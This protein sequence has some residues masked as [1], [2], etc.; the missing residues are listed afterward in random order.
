MSDNPK[1]TQI[2]FLRHVFTLHGASCSPSSDSKHEVTRSCDV[3]CAFLGT[4][5]RLGAAVPSPSCSTG[6]DFDRVYAREHSRS[7]GKSFLCESLSR[8]ERFALEF[9]LRTL[10]CSADGTGMRSHGESGNVRLL[11]QPEYGAVILFSSAPFS[12]DDVDIGVLGLDAWRFQLRGDADAGGGGPRVHGAEAGPERSPMM[13]VGS[14][15][16]ESEQIF[17]K[18]FEQGMAEARSKTGDAR[19]AQNT[20]GGHQMT[21]AFV[22]AC[23]IGALNDNFSC[24]VPRSVESNCQYC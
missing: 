20:G 9:A 24:S 5:L 3:L 4:V 8:T 19:H 6:F 12:P 11:W 17:L 23:C 22:L 15:P 2:D 14:I 10:R 21:P 13:P 18:K 16:R 1:F 7:N